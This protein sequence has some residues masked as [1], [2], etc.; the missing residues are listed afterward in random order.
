MTVHVGTPRKCYLNIY[1]FPYTYINIYLVT[2]LDAKPLSWYL[3]YLCS[4]YAV[5]HFFEARGGLR[6]LDSLRRHAT[7]Q[8]SLKM[9]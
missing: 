6:Q 5:K 4:V 7:P 9:S 8:F 1:Y 2:N 3:I